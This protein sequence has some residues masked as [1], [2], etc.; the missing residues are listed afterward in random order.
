MFNP[1][2]RHRLAALV[3]SVISIAVGTT[4]AQA[5]H[6]SAPAKIAVTLEP[7]IENH[8]LAGAVIL[9]ASPDKVLTVEIIGYADIEAKK[10]MRVDTLFWI[11]S[12][13]K[14]ITASALMMLVDEGKVNIDDPVE[15]YLPEFKGLWLAA[16]KD[17]EHLLLKKPPHPITVKNVLT[18]TSGLPPT[19]AME[20]PTLDLFPLIAG[21]RS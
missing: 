19:S 10:P 18:H 7:F 11:A 5:P 12:M 17:D 20:T 3:L 1:V 8:T 2:I 15:K 13:T 14:P 16:E 21:A 6:S 4:A 9:A